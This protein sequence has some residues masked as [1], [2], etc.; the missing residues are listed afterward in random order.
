MRCVASK[1][2]ENLA[3][4]ND[5][6][7]TFTIR[8]CLQWRGV[9]CDPLVTL[10]LPICLYI[11]YQDWTC[12]L[13][14]ICDVYSAHES[15][16]TESGAKERQVRCRDVGTGFVD[17]GSVQGW[18]RSPPTAVARFRFPDRKSHMGWVCC[19]L[20]SLL[21]GFFSGFP[22]STKSTPQIQF[23]PEKRATGLSALLWSVT[24]TK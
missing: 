11:R 3:D 14:D 22:P 12:F 5:H 2:I 6:C 18:Q 24:L 4:C 1:V 16:V 10:I 9:F 19:W 17:A 20:S 23:D 7:R 15:E 8:L 21:R 13:Q